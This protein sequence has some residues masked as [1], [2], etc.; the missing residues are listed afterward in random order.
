M[1][2]NFLQCE[3]HLIFMNCVLKYVVYFSNVK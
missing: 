3:L 2:E 1:A